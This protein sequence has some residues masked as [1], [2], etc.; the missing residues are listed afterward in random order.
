MSSLKKLK[1][2]EPYEA[3]WKFATAINEM[4]YGACNTVGSVTL[5][6]N[7]TTT[8]LSD[9]NIKRGCKV[10]FSLPKTANAATVTGLWADPTS[11][12]ANGGSITLT[13][14]AVNHSDLEFDY[15]VF[16]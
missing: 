6:Q 13:H 7:G 10:F 8:T 2:S 15:V 4:M 3:L 5:T 9:T 12:P 16:H 14:S 11:I 1:A